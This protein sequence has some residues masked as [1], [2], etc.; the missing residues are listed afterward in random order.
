MTKPLYIA[1]CAGPQTLGLQAT[2]LYHN[3]SELIVRHD[4]KCDCDTCHVYDTDRTTKTL[5]VKQ[6][7]AKR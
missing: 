6:D 2:T 3:Y 7:D 5:I 1:H 4:N